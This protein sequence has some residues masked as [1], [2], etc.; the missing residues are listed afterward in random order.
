[1]ADQIIEPIVI[2]EEEALES[3][4]SP[5]SDQDLLNLDVSVRKQ[6]LQ[7]MDIL[8]EEDYLL[9]S[10]SYAKQRFFL[11]TMDLL[12]AHVGV[13]RTIMPFDRLLIEEVAR[14]FNLV[15]IS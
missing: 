9:G 2:N 4:T 13:L 6:L 1:M 15:I 10:M 11:R 3:P 14:H 7:L 12:I 5:I 8:K